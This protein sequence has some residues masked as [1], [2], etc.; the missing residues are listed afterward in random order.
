MFIMWEKH[1]GTGETEIRTQF[2][3]ENLNRRD[4]LGDLG[5]SLGRREISTINWARGSTIY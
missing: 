3:S 2:W 4:Q 1:V 5:V